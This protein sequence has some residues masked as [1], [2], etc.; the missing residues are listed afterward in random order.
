MELLAKYKFSDWL[1]NR[2]VEHYKKSDISKALIYLEVLGQYQLFAQDIRKLSDQRRHIKELHRNI[3]QALKKGTADK[4]LLTG[5]E[6]TAEFTRE[7][8]AYEDF[9]REQGV[10]EE[11][12]AEY[13]IDR[14]MNYYGNS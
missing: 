11:S 8:K 2:F 6:G 1:Y 10:S 12:I 7:M 4:L 13:V 9:L 3:H 14:K 5:E